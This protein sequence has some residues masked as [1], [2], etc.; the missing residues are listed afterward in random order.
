MDDALAGLR[1][2]LGQAGAAD[3]VV[4]P[5]LAQGQHLVARVALFGHDHVVVAAELLLAAGRNSA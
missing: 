1:A 5:P 3:D 4:Q 2:G